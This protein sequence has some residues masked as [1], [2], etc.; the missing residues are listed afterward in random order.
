MGS[1]PNMFSARHTIDQGYRPANEAR[2]RLASRVGVLVATMIGM[3]FVSNVG[4]GRL[5]TPVHNTQPS[6]I[7]SELANPVTIPLLDRW[8]VMDEISDEIDDYFRIYREERIRT[9]D[10]LITEGWIETWPETGSTLLEPWRRDSTKGFEKLHASL[11]TIRRYAKVRVS[12]LGNSYSVDVK[13]FKELEDNPNP[14]QSGVSGRFFRNDAAIDIDDVS[15]FPEELP[16]NRGWIPLGRDISLEQQ[17]LR[18]IVKRLSGADVSNI[19]N[20]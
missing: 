15:F 19:P 1:L 3:C 9:V 2:H 11:Q 14:I 12:P 17:I 4:C 7:A 6:L 18:N 16:T 20:P 5:Q 13:V 10:N 8:L